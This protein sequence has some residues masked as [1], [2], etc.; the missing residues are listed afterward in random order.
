MA[1]TA[2]AVDFAVLDA[3]ITEL[4]YYDT[5]LTKVWQEMI[6][7][8]DFA[9]KLD[10]RKAKALTAG[11]DATIAALVVAKMQDLLAT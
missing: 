10:T 5:E 1:S 8:L 3:R 6:E 7:G 11:L 9:G 2:T 4:G